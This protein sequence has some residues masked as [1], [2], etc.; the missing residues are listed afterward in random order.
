MRWFR[1]TSIG[2]K[3]LIP[4]AILIVTLATVSLLAVFG[5]DQQRASLGT[6]NDIALDRIS[7]IDE[8]TLLSEQVQSDVFR[9]SVLRLMNLPEE[10]IQPSH[11]RLEQGL[12]DMNVIY[13]QIIAKWSLDPAEKSIL[14][15][16]RGPMDAFRQQALQAAKVVSENPSFG[17]LLVRSSTVPFDE[18]RQTLAEFR[19]YQ[20]EEMVRIESTAT[21]E[22]RAV[23]TAIIAVVPLIALAGIISTVWI[24]TRLIS[25]PTLALADSMQRIAGGDLSAQVGEP[26]RRDEIG[27]M[28]RAIEV[29]RNNALEKARLDQALQESEERFRLAFENANTGMCLLAL[30]SRFI[31]ANSALCKMFGRSQE[32]LETLTFLDIAHPGQAVLA[33]SFTQKALSGQGDSGRFEQA[34]QH[35]EGHSVWGLVSSSL[36]RDPQGSPLYFVSQVQDITETKQAQIEI[37]RRNAELA[38]QN[39]IA[40]TISQ[41]LDMDTVLNTALDTA[42]EV[43]DLEGGAIYLMEPGERMMTLQVHRGISD[44]F[45]Q[46][47]WRIASGEGVTGQAVAQGRPV[48]L[49][50]PN[51]PT[52]RLAPAILKEGICTLVSTPLM[53]KGCALGGLTLAARQPRDFP[54]REL[55]LLGAIGQQIGVAVENARLLEQARQDAETRAGLLHEVNHRVK[56]NL[57]AIL[58]IL[59]L[60]QERPIHA[61]ADFQAVLHDVGNRIK[62]MA[63]V[64]DMLSATK[65]SPLPLRELAS[66]IVRRTLRSSAGQTRMDFTINSPAEPILIPPKQATP[67]ALIFNELSTNSV[68]H[69]F[70]GR[71]RGRIEVSIA[72]EEADKQRVRLEFRDDGPGWPDDVLQGQRESVGLQLLRMNVGSL[73]RGQ[74]DLY[75]DN[76]AVAAITFEAAP[77]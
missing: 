72:T 11:G 12:S 8:F 42:L 59:S 20:Q 1:D 18:F 5:L 71:E 62:G 7:L 52:E 45:A 57:A 41:S 13:G 77:L 74:L 36:V 75:N 3:V 22:A 26:E 19:D 47:V 30:D 31:K 67:L 24:S 10:E 33:A 56:N 54:E 25:R 32:A 9:I 63:T 76:G 40:A 35:E 38:A 53:S 23:T 58:G 2:I 39:A 16:M 49:R 43:L 68:K 60:E 29:F 48:A 28:A 70:S 17:I 37:S 6:V 61:A 46:A 69:A 51:Y 64:H 55:S 15:Q 73:L 14:E 4:P 34:F 21:Q 65:W 44:E 50:V 66:R 27:L